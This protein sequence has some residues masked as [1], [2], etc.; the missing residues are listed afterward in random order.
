MCSISFTQYNDISIV[1]VVLT[2]KDCSEMV[3]VDAIFVNGRLFLCHFHVLQAVKRRLAEA[4]FTTRM[5]DDYHN[6]ITGLFRTA[7]RTTNQNEFEACAAELC[8][9]GKLSD[10]HHIITYSAL[11]ILSRFLYRG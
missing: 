3:A 5:L 11:M 10:V 9:I 7:L 1:K 4:Q 2:D 8:A 6:E